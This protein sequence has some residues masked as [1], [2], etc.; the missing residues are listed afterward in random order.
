MRLYESINSFNPMIFIDRSSFTLI[1]NCIFGHI[2]EF[3]LSIQY[4]IIGLNDISEYFVLLKS[5]MLL[6]DLVILAMSFSFD[7]SSICDD[8]ICLKEWS[9]FCA[10]SSCNNSIISVILDY[11]M[12]FQYIIHQ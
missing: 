2:Y 10:Y 5:I 3:I 12:L 11:Y 8:S 9:L 4:L 1:S 7:A 6:T